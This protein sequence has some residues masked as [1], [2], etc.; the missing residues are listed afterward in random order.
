MN[1]IKPVFTTWPELG[2]VRIKTGLEIMDRKMIKTSLN[3]LESVGI[4]SWL[5]HFEEPIKS[6]RSC[7][8]NV[9]DLIICIGSRDIM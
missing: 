8:P 6:L 1:Q 2:L 9:K 5:N 3:Q 4:Y 7:L